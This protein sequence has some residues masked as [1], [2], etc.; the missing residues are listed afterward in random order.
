VAQGSREGDVRVWH[1][2]EPGSDIH[3]LKVNPQRAPSRRQQR[4][5]RALHARVADW[6]YPPQVAADVDAPLE[7][8]L[9]LVNE[10]APGRGG[11]SEHDSAMK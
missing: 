1:R 10:V 6:G 8:L 2:P 11:P 3:A 4:P 5:R 7:Y 9:V